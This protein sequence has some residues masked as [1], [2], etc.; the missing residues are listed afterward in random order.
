MIVRRGSAVPHYRIEHIST[1]QFLFTK[2]SAVDLLF[3]IIELNIFQ[4]SNFSSPRGMIFVSIHIS[5]RVSPLSNLTHRNSLSLCPRRGMI[6]LLLPLYLSIKCLR[7]AEISNQGYSSTL[8]EFVLWW[9][10][11]TDSISVTWSICI[12][13]FPL[14][15]L[16][17]C[18]VK[19]FAIDCRIN[20][21]SILYKNPWVLC[22][23]TKY[24]VCHSNILSQVLTLQHGLW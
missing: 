8:F 22:F 3:R 15:K 13:H 20:T 12:M 19:K 23:I 21:K 18:Q 11:N 5:L 10:I 17:T 4:Q 1:V 7:A 6:C 9:R 16:V 24:D 2:L 14:S